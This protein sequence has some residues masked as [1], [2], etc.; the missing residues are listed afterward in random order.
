MRLKKRLVAIITTVILLA[1]FASIASAAEAPKEMFDAI[2]AAKKEQYFNYKEGSLKLTDFNEITVNDPE[3]DTGTV[4]MA[5][6]E[7][8]KARD[9]IF[10]LK[11]KEIVYYDPENGE[12]L[13]EAHLATVDEAAVYKDSFGGILGEKLQL[14]LIT[15][16]LII[17]PIVYVFFI[18]FAW[19]PRQY[20]T[21]K[22]KIANKL[23]DGV[24]KSFN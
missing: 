20:L 6:A 23:F 9:T 19:E 8:D 5:L 3:L 12:I 1:S 4:Q 2:N 7:Y 15:V 10:V 13:Q 22:F 16:L 17:L 21:T 14:G 24:H 11:T 18:V